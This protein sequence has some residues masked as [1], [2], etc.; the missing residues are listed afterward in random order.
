MIE[1][2]ENVSTL[3]NREDSSEN[4]QSPET[5]I[6]KYKSVMRRETK[7]NN[8]GSHERLVSRKSNLPYHRKLEMS[9]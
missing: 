1:N 8:L 9:D 5:E 6:S 2:D 3:I 7:L 4:K